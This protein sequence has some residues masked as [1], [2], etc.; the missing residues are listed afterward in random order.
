MS[1]HTVVRCLVLFSFLFVFFFCFLE[2]FQSFF[3][4]DRPSK[5]THIRLLLFFSFFFFSLS[6]S[7]ELL[8]HIPSLKSCAQHLL[9]F[10]DPAILPDFGFGSWKRKKEQQQQQ[11]EGPN[12]TFLQSIGRIVRKPNFKKN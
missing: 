1:G 2:F 12:P 9:F 5:A 11:K 6:L 10:Y 4:P 8:T 7:L 3:E